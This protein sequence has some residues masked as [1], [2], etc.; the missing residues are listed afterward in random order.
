M[1]GVNHDDDDDGASSIGDPEGKKKKNRLKALTKSVT[2]R[3]RS[4][5]PSKSKHGDSSDQLD[6]KTKAALDAAHSGDRDEKT[7]MLLDGL[8]SDLREAEEAV[9]R[10]SED[11]DSKIEQL[12]K[13]RDKL[14]R[15]SGGD[16]TALKNRLN[17]EQDKRETIE[18]DLS[19]RTAKVNLLTAELDTSQQQLTKMEQAN[20]YLKKDLEAMESL[21]NSFERKV[22]TLSLLQQKLSDKDRELGNVTSENDTL[23]SEKHSLTAQLADVKKEHEEVTR[24]LLERADEVSDLMWKMDALG[25]QVETLESARAKLEGEKTEMEKM[26]FDTSKAKSVHIDDQRS[27]GDDQIFGWTPPRTTHQQRMTSFGLTNTEVNSDDV[28]SEASEGGDKLV[29]GTP[30]QKKAAEVVLVNELKGELMAMSTEIEELKLAL[31]TTQQE[32][33][34]LVVKAKAMSEVIEAQSTAPSLNDLDTSN[35]ELSEVKKMNE[36]LNLLLEAER[37]DRDDELS[38]V[39]CSLRDVEVKLEQ[40]ERDRE[41]LILTLSRAEMHKEDIEAHH[42]I[43]VNE[44]KE[45]KV[46]MS[47]VKVKNDGLVAVVKSHELEND[48]ATLQFRLGVNSEQDRIGE[49][50]QRGV[51]GVSEWD[52]V[53]I[54]E[55]MFDGSP[56]SRSGGGSVS[57]PHEL[58]KRID[59]LEREKDYLSDRCETLRSMLEEANNQIDEASPELMFV[60]ETEKEALN[61]SLRKSDEM[62]KSLSE[63]VKALTRSV[64]EGEDELERL[65]GRVRELSVALDQAEMKAMSATLDQAAGSQ[66]EREVTME[67]Q[68]VSLRD[69]LKREEETGQELVMEKNELVMEKNSLKRLMGQQIDQIN[70]LQT[71]LP[72]KEIELSE[73]IRVKERLE[74]ENVALTDTNMDLKIQVADLEESVVKLRS[75]KNQLISQQASTALSGDES[76]D[77]RL[78]ELEGILSKTTVELET[79]EHRVT[80]LQASIREAQHEVDSVRQQ[81]KSEAKATDELRSSLAEK[82][83]Q[84]LALELQKIRAE[85]LNSS[86]E[87]DLK[88]TQDKL[89]AL[90]KAKQLALQQVEEANATINQLQKQINDL[91]RVNE[92]SQ[93]ETS[94]K[95]LKMSEESNAEKNLM[96]AQ[97]TELKKLNE[98]AR[99]TEL[100]RSVPVL[101]GEEDQ[102]S[103]RKLEAAL[104]QA[105]QEAQQAQSQ[106][107]AYEEREQQ[108]REQIQDLQYRNKSDG[109]YHHNKSGQPPQGITVSNC[110][111]V[112]ESVPSFVA[113]PASSPNN[114]NVNISRLDIVCVIKDRLVDAVFPITSET[115]ELKGLGE[116]RNGEGADNGFL[117]D[118]EMKRISVSMN[119]IQKLWELGDDLRSGLISLD[120]RLA[121]RADKSGD[122]RLGDE[123]R[124]SLEL[125]RTAVERLERRNNELQVMCRSHA[126]ATREARAVA[127]LE[128]E[129][130]RVLRRSF[131][132]SGRGRID[133]EREQLLVEAY[134]LRSQI[135]RVMGENRTLQT[136]ASKLHSLPA[137]KE[138][139]N[140]LHQEMYE[141]KAFALKLPDT[142]KGQEMLLSSLMGTLA[143]AEHRSATVFESLEESRG[144]SRAHSTQDAVAGY[145]LAEHHGNSQKFSAFSNGQS[146]HLLPP[147]SHQRYASNSPGGGFD[148]RAAM[149]YYSSVRGEGGPR[150]G[151]ASSTTSIHPQSRMAIMSA[152]AAANR[153]LN[154]ADF[155][156][157]FAELQ[158][159]PATQPR[160]GYETAGCEPPRLQNRQIVKRSNDFFPTNTTAP[161]SAGLGGVID[162]GR[163]DGGKDYVA[164]ERSLPTGDRPHPTQQQQDLQGHPQPRPQSHPLPQP[165]SPQSRAYDPSQHSQP[166]TE[167]P[168]DRPSAVNRQSRYS[169]SHID[170]PTANY[171]VPAPIH[172]SYAPP[173]AAPHLSEAASQLR[174]RSVPTGASPPNDQIDS[175]LSNRY[176][177][178]RQR[179]EGGYENRVAPSSSNNETSM[180]GVMP[181]PL[182]VTADG[183]F[184]NTGEAQLGSDALGAVGRSSQR[185]PGPAHQNT[186]PTQAGQA[187]H[188]QLSQTRPLDSQQS[189]GQHTSHKPANVD[190]AHHLQ[191]TENPPTH[192]QRPIGYTQHPTAT[193]TQQQYTAPYIP[194]K[195]SHPNYTSPQFCYPTKTDKSDIIDTHSQYPNEKTGQFTTLAS[196]RQY[197]E[198]GELRGQTPGG[199]RW[200]ADG[201]G[202]G[203]DERFNRSGD[204][205][206]S[207]ISGS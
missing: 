45:V 193:H 96:Q 50:R 22:E 42:I 106:L 29:C 25:K 92:E 100:S 91:K 85:T 140:S 11:R 115:G 139:F 88:L 187:S 73:M 179:D 185:Y 69:A 177:S 68:L 105:S 126:D 1:L 82:E 158:S 30:P 121:L 17:E 83:K 59:E 188:P 49:V 70:S 154:S 159:L 48:G 204:G 87:T 89:D 53:P 8:V 26:L 47:E 122:G 44:L 150:R 157:S 161:M 119:R 23:R 155:P 7:Q 116:M 168:I 74:G 206:R 198:I 175:R 86:L 112:G 65:R 134:R 107:E 98:D 37:K 56:S 169:P 10:I 165:S 78:R 77:K 72:A 16:T 127:M 27:V 180:D 160:Y 64:A 34:E 207:R 41:I 3:S 4:K 182:R 63:Q 148:K 13:E 152:V 31:D 15:S 114:S 39:R 162:D 104:R 138:S 32:R 194:A 24:Q 131:A 117:S 200:Q 38:S 110:V 95:L 144:H 174:P 170:S 128:S 199:D 61:E 147:Q 97:I 178:D 54:N 111:I 2:K 195:Q 33:D 172:T 79:A 71:Q 197:G 113:A 124:S 201:G 102:E 52:D 151:D 46:E 93:K 81:R 190:I 12:Q 141:L 80:S 118:N 130:S 186:Q 136:V 84:R 205:Y 35:A 28:M 90:N 75:E 189:Q 146:P 202:V 108:L 67:A 55:L 181:S 60:A 66:S 5:G 62:N 166:I 94:A 99:A 101:M 173:I 18:R 43:L 120:P 21:K 129:R 142:L 76:K 135:N 19:E 36:D 196:E 132:D 163:S 9:Q 184:H 156:H 125:I 183:G 20:Q 133:S 153:K 6:E 145:G 123:W 137:L 149:E 203:I 58:K 192:A 14:E 57:D 109:S 176:K 191:H 171:G 103:K 164:R 143:T 167:H 51:T 40:T